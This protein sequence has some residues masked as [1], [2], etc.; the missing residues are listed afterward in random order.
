MTWHWRFETTDGTTVERHRI[1]ALIPHG[2][3]PAALA[4][5]GKVDLP[6]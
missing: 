5:A 4:D 3:G 6:A 2:F 1:N